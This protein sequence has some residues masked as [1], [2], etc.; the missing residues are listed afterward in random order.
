MIVLYS[1][2]IIYILYKILCISLS[3]YL[4]FLYKSDRLHKENVYIVFYKPRRNI[5]KFIKNLFNGC[6]FSSG[7]IIGDKLYQMRKENNTLQERNYTI[8]YIYD[9]YLVINTGFKTCDLKKNWRKKLL[10]QKARQLKTLYLRKNCLRSLRFVLNQI[11][12]FKYNGEV[13]PII[14]LYKLLKFNNNE[15][16]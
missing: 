1:I 13:L 3:I 6:L 4:C 10:Q 15:R 16:K 7:L 5:F 9:K 11:N 12:N 14:Y 8:K 2:L